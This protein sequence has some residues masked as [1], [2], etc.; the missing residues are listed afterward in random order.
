[1]TDIQNNISGATPNN[2]L[3]TPQMVDTLK[4]GG[5]L[6][7]QPIDHLSPPPT[8]T[9]E[10]KG[11]IAQSRAE[12]EREKED[13][14]P[15]FWESLKISALHE[16]PT[17]SFFFNRPPDYYEDDP[18][19]IINDELDTHL[20]SNLSEPFWEEVYE[21]A[22]SEKEFKD[23]VSFYKNTEEEI[24][25]LWSSSWSYL[26]VPLASM[27]DPAYIAAFAATGGVAT[28]VGLGAKATM[29]VTK[30]GISAMRVNYLQSALRGAGIFG[31]AEGMV[32][33][34]RL[35]YDPYWE[36]H[37]AIFATAL[38]APVGGGFGLVRAAWKNMRMAPDEVIVQDAARAG[39]TPL[40]QETLRSSLAKAPKPDVGDMS[41]EALIARIADD[42]GAPLRLV[43][44][45][46]SV[47]LNT[48]INR[49]VSKYQRLGY[50][51][52]DDIDDAIEQLSDVLKPAEKGKLRKLWDTA[53]DAE[54]KQIDDSLKAS[55]LPP[56][57]D[58]VV[59]PTGRTLIA[60]VVNLGDDVPPLHEG[61]T[62]AA[63]SLKGYIEKIF[64][65]RGIKV[66][67]E[68]YDSTIDGIF[69][70][71]TP[72]QQRR[73]TTLFDDAADAEDIILDWGKNSTPNP[74]RAA[75][76]A[77]TA[78]SA[79][80]RLLAKAYENVDPGD[81][82]AALDTPEST[83]YREILMKALKKAGINVRVDDDIEA[84]VRVLW[85]DLSPEVRV[86][87]KES[88]L[89][90]QDAEDVMI[91]RAAR[92]TPVE[93]DLLPG[94]KKPTAKPKPDVDPE[95]PRPKPDVDPEAP[96]PKPD[97][98]PEA[99]PPKPPDVAPEIA[100]RPIADVP[101]QR[102]PW[103]EGKNW[104]L[105][106]QWIGAIVDGP[107]VRMLASTSQAV[108]NFAEE[109]FNN[110]L[111]RRGGS[112]H[113]ASVQASG[114]TDTLLSKFFRDGGLRGTTG[115][116]Y[117]QGREALLAIRNR[118]DLDSLDPRVGKLV[119]AVQEHMKDLVHYAEAHGIKVPTI[120]PFHFPRSWSRY[121]IQ[122]ADIEVGEAVVGEL[123][124]GSLRAGLL[125]DGLKWTN[126]AI[127]QVSEH[128][129]KI[130]RDPEYQSMVKARE[131]NPDWAGWVQ[132]VRSEMSGKGLSK[133]QIDEV[134]DYVDVR[135][136][137][138]KPS[139]LRRRIPFAEDFS[140]TTASGKVLRI[141]TL[142]DDNLED[143]VRRV[144][145]R[146][147]GYVEW[148][149]ALKRRGVDPDISFPDLMVK[150]GASPNEVKNFKYVFN[151]MNGLPN[152]NAEHKWWAKILKYLQDSAVITKGAEM[153]LSSWSEV[154]SLASFYG[155]KYT[156][157]FVPGYLRVL[158]KLTGGTW[159]DPVAFKEF[160]NLT[161]SG[162]MVS[163]YNLGTRVN[164]NFGYAG[165][166]RTGSGAIR[167]I[168]NFADNTMNDLRKW[169]MMATPTSVGRVST[170]AQRGAMDGSM[171]YWANAA[172]RVTAKGEVRAAKDM[173]DQT[174]TR[175][176]SLGAT[177]EMIDD[178]LKVMRDP[179]IVDVEKSIGQNI[180]S[181]NFDRW[182]PT[183][184]REFRA[185]NQSALERIVQRVDVGDLPIYFRNPVARLYLQFLSHPVTAMNK[186]TQY[187]ARSKDF[188]SV[189]YFALTTG[190]AAL[191]YVAK[192][193]D[194]LWGMGLT[195]AEKRAYR[196]KWFTPEGIALNAM[197]M[198]DGF[199]FL[200]DMTGPVVGSVTGEDPF[201]PDAPTSMKVATNIVTSAPGFQS[202]DAASSVA[203]KTAQGDLPAAWEIFIDKLMPL[204]NA[205]GMP[206][207]LHQSGIK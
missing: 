132:R 73:F 185:L 97:V 145:Q 156:G 58:P 16:T 144:T 78:A 207:L 143:A 13:N 83:V 189:K 42:G 74:V 153:G 39:A 190:M 158:R 134:L 96:R 101:R 88:F 175:L 50:T 183:L 14:I 4:R 122:K 118:L 150:L 69:D 204:G 64:A 95:A 55:G 6:P 186:K 102:R 57:T 203:I 94:A 195:D 117:R 127:K 151:D 168:T 126:K 172:Y 147:T 11:Q 23:L 121:L 63:I 184:L 19:F 191:A 40:Q 9:T 112:V 163:N 148:R 124:E 109:L 34:P 129:L 136:K 59:E 194:K 22:G 114:Q 110:P 89:K 31:V 164:Y 98:D 53:A 103:G 60:R 51:V 30:A 76:A 130:F 140:I 72:S 28:A 199:G 84:M 116:R 1:M 108:R 3:I 100:P 111:G 71:L 79:D 139:F 75:K 177:D 99:P 149:E 62:P 25:R 56:R 18:N 128:T 67:P 160:Q 159:R 179:H 90:A 104:S 182:P 141:S 138:T 47:S 15:G 166:P 201:N 85:K 21:R 36:A 35:A 115:N 162:M 200:S 157:A 93:V 170:E 173:V 41:A 152:T 24:D 171:R 188:T 43:E 181:W 2:P 135:P 27:A 167:S 113:S 178:I 192:Q 142:M 65:R 106:F 32:S 125:R 54:A 206:Q 48:Y 91:A 187:H 105:P 29:G 17:G 33:I 155:I 81:R 202:L 133:N 123:F 5:P 197:R 174:T 205:M 80:E 26:T 82:L 45:P 20:T 77:E 66:N 154:G 49:L 12:A 52:S 44:T 146:F 38:A 198:N 37:E 86:A 68:D 137:S 180:V 70:S 8:Y 196:N 92:S 131:S 161:G 193:E 165:S 119:A 107:N 46:Q 61:N 176:R 7:P 169:S 87:I 120:D 10:Q